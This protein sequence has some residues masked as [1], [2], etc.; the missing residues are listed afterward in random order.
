MLTTGET[1][2]QQQAPAQPRLP[3]MRPCSDSMSGCAPPA[4]A[5]CWPAK[6]PVQQQA[7]ALHYMPQT[8]SW[9]LCNL[10]VGIAG[11]CPTA[12]HLLA[13]HARHGMLHAAAQAEHE[14]LQQQLQASVLLPAKAPATQL[15]WKGG[16]RE[17]T[18]AG[19][20]RTPLH[21]PAKTPARRRGGGEA[22]VVDNNGCEPARIAAL[23]EAFTHTYVRP[24]LTHASD[25][26]SHMSST[27]PDT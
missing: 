1:P 22:D 13:Q 9:P 23:L 24:H 12:P 4:D 20:Q 19:R 5:A 25:P 18:A 8:P 16:E 3:P 6:R 10:L 15:F 11:A 26:T 27:P 14:G 2:E 21:R 7:P 17:E